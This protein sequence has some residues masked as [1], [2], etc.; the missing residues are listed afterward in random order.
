MSDFPEIPQLYGLESNQWFFES[1]ERSQV[2]YDQER[3]QHVVLQNAKLKVELRQLKRELLPAEDVKQLGAEL[4]AAIRKVLTRLH[5]LAPSLVGH[6]VDVIEARLKEEEDGVLTQL[7]LLDE[8][9]GQW[10]KASTE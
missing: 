1:P 10:Q 8:Q 7:H 2:T 6:P 5:R 4:G 9:L 3:A